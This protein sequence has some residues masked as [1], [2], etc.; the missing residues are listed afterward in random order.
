MKK[1]VCGMCGGPADCDYTIMVE[2]EQE[3]FQKWMPHWKENHQDMM[4][5]HNE[6][7]KQAWFD[8]HHQVWESTP[9]EL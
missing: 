5:G 9:D 3:A 2:T 8:N 7:D 1:L 6:E 4:Q